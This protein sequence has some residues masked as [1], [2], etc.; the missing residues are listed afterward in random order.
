MLTLAISKKTIEDIYFE[1]K[2]KLCEI[3]IRLVGAEVDLLHV[4]DHPYGTEKFLEF[5]SR[6]MATENLMF[7]HAV[8]TFDSMCLALLKLFGE[9]KRIRT[10]LDKNLAT[11]ALIQGADDP[12]PRCGPDDSPPQ[13]NDRAAAS[14]AAYTTTSDTLSLS[15]LT[16]APAPSTITPSVITTTTVISS[17]A[18]VD[19]Y[20]QEEIVN[21]E[22]MSRILAEF[23]QRVPNY[24]APHLRALQEHYT[25]GD[26]TDR[27]RMPGMANQ[28]SVNTEAFGRLGAFAGSVDGQDGLGSVASGA[29]DVD[30]SD[31]LEELPIFDPRSKPPVEEATPPGADNNTVAPFVE[32]THTPTTA[33]PEAEN[34]RKRLT[35]NSMLRDKLF[36]SVPRSDRTHINANEESHLLVDPL[37]VVGVSRVNDEHMA[38]NLVQ[39]NQMLF[40]K[41]QRKINKIQDST[42]ELKEV[43]RSM[44]ETYIHEKSPSQVNISSVTRKSMERRFR[45][46]VVAG[47]GTPEVS[48]NS[49]LTSLRQSTVESDAVGPSDPFGV[50][51]DALRRRSAPGVA[52][53]DSP[54]RPVLPLSVETTPIGSAV[55]SYLDMQFTSLFDEAKSEVLKI[56]RLDSFQ[57]W[58]RTPEFTAFINSFQ[59]IEKQASRSERADGVTEGMSRSMD[60]S[61]LVGN[62]PSRAA[63]ILHPIHGVIS[64][65]SE[66]NPVPSPQLAAGAG[67]PSSGGLLNGLSFR[68]SPNART[69]SAILSPA[70]SAGQMPAADD[71]FSLS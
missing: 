19:A 57:R 59:R 65:N 49:S 35:K 53:M 15:T 39:L 30:E 52:V 46:W 55:H 24:T 51:N 56:M 45:E 34:G 66:K 41:I 38:A 63:I 6:T 22:T 25:S 64:N 33:A 29:S 26:D 17:T 36:V 61:A 2:A 20:A 5:L 7:Y 12:V 27:E 23:D 69:T 37:G 71:S 28:Y 47:L 70:K 18:A 9:V 11:L 8:D 42:V 1:N 68:F 50:A 43:A 3:R 10:K 44:M 60:E 31:V 54:L 62:H 58:K 13:L 16:T 48:R 67:A 4:I 21:A 32:E 40:A 14:T